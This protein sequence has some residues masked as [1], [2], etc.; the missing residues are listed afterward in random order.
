MKRNSRSLRI[1]KRKAEHGN[2]KDY[3]K[4]ELFP[5]T[6]IGT[7]AIID[8]DIIIINEKVIKNE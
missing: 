8:D 2:P 3:C 1:I 7:I 5:S 6:P 4:V